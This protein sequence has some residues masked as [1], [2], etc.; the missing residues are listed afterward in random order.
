MYVQHVR[1]E[2]FV[3]LTLVCM[4]VQC[5][6]ADFLEKLTISWYNKFLCMYMVSEQIVLDLLTFLMYVCTA[7]QS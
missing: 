7:C 3:Q 1:A 5:V 6:R 4:Y 2:I